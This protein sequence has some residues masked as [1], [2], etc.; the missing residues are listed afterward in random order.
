MGWS[1]WSLEAT[2]YPGYG[3]MNW[4]TAEHVKE[5]SDTLHKTLQK[6]GYNYINMDS[7]WHGGFDEYGR[8][9]WDAKKFPGGISEVAQ[10]VHRNGQKLGIYWIP[11][12]S[13]D[14]YD[15]NCPI[16]GT[17]YHI[18]DIVAVPEMPANGWGFNRK[19]D[20]SKPG[21]Q[22]Y[23]SSIAEL[24]ASWGVDFLKFDGVV[25]GSHHDNTVDTRPDVAAWSKALK[26]TGRKIWFELSWRLEQNYAA[27][28]REHANG[29]RIEGDVESYTSKLT[30]WDQIGWRFAMSHKWANEAG[31]GK[32]WND[33]DSVI[34]G[35]GEMDGI[36]PDE[37]RTMMTLWA[38]ACSPLYIGDDLTKLDDYGM[39]LLTN[40]EV[41]AVDQAGRPARALSLD[42]MQVWFSKAADGS[43]VVALFNLDSIND[44]DITAKWSDIGLKG[45]VK[46]R[47]LWSHT[48]LGSFTESF[49]A[50]LAPHACRLLRIK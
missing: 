23:I 38:I 25:P 26:R 11:G 7:G 40:K 4:L 9:I 18:Q 41:I 36:T 45:S 43:T 21:A 19:I 31:P 50:R 39:D 44:A 47:D 13:G 29:W 5:Q 22:E 30:A 32:G 28:W 46:V 20:F 12:I 33:L 2:S 27:F 42:N 37:R 16:L 15:K 35:N 49:T 14:I 34:V 6:Y 3:G 8:P 1:S 48:E 17:P 10:H 24:F